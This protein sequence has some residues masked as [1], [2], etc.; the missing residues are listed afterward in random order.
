MSVTEREYKEKTQ[1]IDDRETLYAARTARDILWP[2]E[3]GLNDW[4]EVNQR[5]VDLFVQSKQH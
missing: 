2:G 5:Y 4:L 3:I 1:R